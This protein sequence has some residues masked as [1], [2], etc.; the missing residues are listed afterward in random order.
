MTLTLFG[1]GVN[2]L[3]AFRDG[4][5][6]LGVLRSLAQPDEPSGVSD[7]GMT[8]VNSM[9]LS[10]NCVCCRLLIV[11][12]SASSGQKA[13]LTTQNVFDFTV[14]FFLNWLIHQTDFRS[15]IISI[16]MTMV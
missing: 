10:L 6:D 14:D 4:V 8:L 12:C 1:D 7:K 9:T 5:N 13:F 3:D 2:D 15:R 11:R 16:I